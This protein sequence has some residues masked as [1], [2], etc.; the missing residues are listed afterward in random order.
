MREAKGR[1]SD[2]LGTDYP[3][4]S[5]AL[6]TAVQNALS[7]SATPEAALQAAQEQVESELG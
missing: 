3:V 7:G 6:W 5:E 1:T 4:I 2:D